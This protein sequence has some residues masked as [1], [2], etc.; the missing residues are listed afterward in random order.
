M[1][2]IEKFNNGNFT[3]DV[4]GTYEEPLFKAI[5]VCKMLNY[6]SYNQVI[7]NLPQEYKKKITVTH[8]HTDRFRQNQ[9]PRTYN[10]LTEN[11]LYYLIM[12]CDLPAA[13]QFQKWVCSDVL[14]SIRKK[15]Y[16]TVEQKQIMHKTN[17]KIETEYDLH[18]KVID[19]IRSKY[20]ESLYTASLGEMQ[21]TSDKRIKAYQMGY[22]KGECDLSILNLHKK[23]SG[24]ILEFK[25]PTGQGII[26][27][28]QSLRLKKYRLNGF[29]T[30]LSNDYDTIIMEIADYMANTRIKCDYCAGKFK[31]LSTLKNH[32]K[33]IHRIK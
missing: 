11:G 7:D 9:P 1:N 28:F 27:K 16:Y 5:E 21:D 25:S 13:K 20:P 30:L 29:K 6:K 26:N 22:T 31:N 10:L 14:P 4:Y 32:L 15:G 24:F 23:Y 33:Y 12:R 17:F 18:T 8:N 3:L 2:L 19:F